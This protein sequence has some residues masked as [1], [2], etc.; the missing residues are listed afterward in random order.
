MRR[1]KKPGLASR[2]FLVVLIAGLIAA[3]LVVDRGT[4]LSFVRAWDCVKYNFIVEQNG[5]VYVHNASD[6]NGSASR[7]DV[8][9]NDILVATLDVPATTRRSNPIKIGSVTVPANGVFSWKASLEKDRRCTDTGSYTQPI[10]PCNFVELKV[11]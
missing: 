2:M 5:D 8:S 6:Y 3:V 9:I 1:T 10:I 4:G 7:A 11:P